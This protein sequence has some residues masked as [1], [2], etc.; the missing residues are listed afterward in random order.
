M[1]NSP[2]WWRALLWGVAVA[3]PLLGLMLTQAM[4]HQRSDLR[5]RCE[6]SMFVAGQSEPKRVQLDVRIQEGMAEL[7]Y[8][9]ER[10]NR[11]LGAVRLSGQLTDWVP[12]NLCYQLSLDKGQVLMDFTQS[13]LPD[14]L[15][16]VLLMG[17]EPLLRGESLSVNFKMLEQSGSRALLGFDDSN[18]LWSCE[19]KKQGPMG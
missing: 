4:S 9:I 15:Q 6:S 17:R 2:L 7:V 13:Q 18:A 16:Q 19:V 3:L 11:E 5:L 1:T 8:G 10:D 12:A 14:H